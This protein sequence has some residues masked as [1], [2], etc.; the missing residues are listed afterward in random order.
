MTGIVV[1]FAKPEEVRAIK[2]LLLRGGYTVNAS[3]TSGA[4]ALSR[5][6]DMGA[7][8][9]V[10]GYKL[11]DMMFSNVA[12]NM[13]PGCEMLVLAPEA[14]A[15]DCI[16]IPHVRVITMPLKGAAFLEETGAVLYEME[17]LRRKKRETPT[18][19]SGPQAELVQK[20]K[21]LLMEKKGMTEEQAHRYL[22]KT[23]MDNG[24]SMAETAEKLILLNKDSNK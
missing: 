13:P 11:P 24:V 17:R 5:L 7:S 1:A 12:E 22:Q 10:C 19:R 21:A 9:V 6:D 14:R 8:L 3:S 23:S 18:S 4:G 2:N 20:A 16:G 15:G